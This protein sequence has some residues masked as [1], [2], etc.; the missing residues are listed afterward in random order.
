MNALKIPAPG[1]N[2]LVLSD[3]LHLENYNVECLQE[4]LF[5]FPFDP[6]HNEGG[7]GPI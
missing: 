1:W 4:L 2:T 3:V 7:V 6:K 5:L